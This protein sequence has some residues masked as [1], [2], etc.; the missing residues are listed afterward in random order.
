MLQGT[1]VLG[2]HPDGKQALGV[3][4]LG[5][6][7]QTGVQIG[8][9]TDGNGVIQTRGGGVHPLYEGTQ[10]GTQPLPPSNV[11][12]IPPAQ[13]P[14]PP[15]KSIPAQTNPPIIYSLTIV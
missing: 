4:T 8:A 15:K 10:M 7:V 1:Q 11:Q 3:H 5:E 13:P 14:P 9:H 12:S 6:G 2:T